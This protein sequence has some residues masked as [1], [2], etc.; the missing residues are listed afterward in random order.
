MG[1]EAMSRR[2]HCCNHDC[3][4]G[5]DCPERAAK[6]AKVKA[7][8]PSL[9]HKPPGRAAQHHLPVYLRH[10]AKWMLICLAV[11]TI[12]P[13]VLSVALAK[14]RPAS[15]CEQLLARDFVPAHVRIKCKGGV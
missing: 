11:M 2:D 1:G 13:A 14:Q 5:R 10:L 8:R 12:T 6:V 15:K 3:N 7:S 4:Q 9:K